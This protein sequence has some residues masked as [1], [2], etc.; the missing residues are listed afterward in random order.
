MVHLPSGCWSEFIKDFGIGFLRRVAGGG[1][2][3]RP[4][5]RITRTMRGEGR[6]GQQ[7]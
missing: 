5:R 1:H 3:I 2:E 4:G 7:T 6:L